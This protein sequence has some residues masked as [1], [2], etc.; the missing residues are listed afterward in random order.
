VRTVHYDSFRLG[1][2]EIL[3]LV[4]SLGMFQI[5]MNS[6]MNL[7]AGLVVVVRG[8][9]YHYFAEEKFVI[10]AVS[11]QYLPTYNA[12]HRRIIP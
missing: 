9:M 6:R 3:D 12:T 11:I 5:C 1:H 10:Q 7:G 8:A 4:Q 2:D